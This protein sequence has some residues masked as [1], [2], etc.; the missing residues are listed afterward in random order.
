MHESDPA[1]LVASTAEEIVAAVAADAERLAVFRRRWIVAL[2]DAGILDI[3]GNEW[4]RIGRS[5][6][7]LGELSFDRADDLL[8]RLED[9]G[10]IPL[11]RAVSCHGQRLL[12]WG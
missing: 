7:E 11:P 12:P 3:V 6:I 5:S 9:L 1:S 2:R 8:R 4:V 10:R